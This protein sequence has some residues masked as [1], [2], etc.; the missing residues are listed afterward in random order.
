MMAGVDYRIVAEAYADLERA[1]GRL[2]L[3]DRMAELVRGTPVELLP[4]VCYLCQGHDR[5][6]VRRDRPR[7]GREAGGPGGRHRGRRRAGRGGRRGARGR[8]PG[9]GRGGSCSA[10]APR[11]GRPAWRCD[12][13]RHPARDRRRRGHRLAGPQ[14]RPAGRAARRG[15][16][17]WRRRY[18]LRLVTG[19][20]RLGIGTPTILDALAEV[21]A[22]GR[23]D[24]P[25][26]ERAYNICCDLGLVAATLARGG[27]AAV[28]RLEVRP[29][30]PVRVMLAQRL[31]EAAEILAKL[32]GECAAE[33]KY[34]GIRIQAHR[35]A[36]GQIELFTRGW[37]G[38]AT[39]SPTWSSCSAPG[40]ARARRSSRARRSRTTRRPASCARSRRSCSG[41]AST[42]SPRRSG[43]CRSACS[44][45]TCCTP[46]A[47]T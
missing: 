47:R 36:D 9:P 8:R 35:T 26:L 22:G 14:A 7:A 10:A 34:D 46:T 21:H 2:A 29:G 23:T 24:R 43:T 44:A 6:P 39:S 18:L 20:L 11:T 30:N 28:E 1:T 42:A 41:G 16:P 27:L 25:V 40:S 19:N 5:A 12:R 3:I 17:R 37:S 13:G 4:T 38:S 45:S 33:Y 31:S 15:P 32:G